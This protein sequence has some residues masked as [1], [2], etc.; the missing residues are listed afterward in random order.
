M[1]GDGDKKGLAR[2]PGAGLRAPAIGP[3]T[4]LSYRTIE[5]L[6]LAD[7]SL[8]QSLLTG[9]VMRRCTLVKVD[10][11]RC[12]LD[13]MRIENCRFVD[14][15][16]GNADIRSASVSRTVFER[17]AFDNAGI[18]DVSFSATRFSRS[19][20]ATAGVSE[21]SFTECSF[22]ETSLAQ[23]SFT[24]N[25][26][27]STTFSGMVLGD[28]T[29]LYT[30]LRGCT[31]TKT[32]INAESIGL[33][34][35]LGAQDVLAMPVMFLG[36]EQDAVGDPS[37]LIPALMAQ[38]QERRWY[39]GLCV[40]RLNFGLTSAA[41]AIGEYLLMLRE[42]SGAGLLLKRDELAFFGTVVEE[43]ARDERL[44]LMSCIDAIE[45]CGALE[46]NQRAGRE[47]ERRH[48]AVAIQSLSSRLF[49]VLQDL[50]ERLERQSPALRSRA[51]DVAV[52]ATLRFG[53]RPSLALPKLLNQVAAASGLGIAARSRSLARRE[54]SYVEVIQTT[55][56]TLV[57][58]QIFI[59]LL[60]G[61]VIQLT[62][63]RAR[64]KALT[65]SKVPAPY[66]R[67]ALEPR[68][69][70][71]AHLVATIKTIMGLASAF[72]ALEHSDLGGVAPPNLRSVTWKRPKS[73]RKR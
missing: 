39:L 45:T 6:E 58:L 2:R 72:P 37:G 28:C 17:C 34:F 61:C 8:K 49:M 24:Q 66:A 9:S 55:L 54:G 33:T 56:M 59:Y 11:S 40:M 27:T 13:G 19:T 21:C 35:G 71:P 31:F 62:E 73:P 29:F 12:D 5:G 15:K 65:G 38:Y 36:E 20:F 52:E 60:N 44:P 30:V 50:L 63:L 7:R 4:D 57:A 16:F 70:L 48:A 69:E 32:K 14:C 26:F 1:S 43:L 53:H 3:S 25:R 46:E 47:V 42:A 22:D 67:R 18:A 23:S 68:Q 64:V 41:H 10:L 51:A